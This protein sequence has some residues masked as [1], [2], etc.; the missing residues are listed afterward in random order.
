MAHQLY[1]VD[2]FLG[3]L[4][5]GSLGCLLQRESEALKCLVLI[6]HADLRL[7]LQG[8]TSKRKHFFNPQKENPQRVEEDGFNCLTFIQKIALI[9]PNRFFLCFPLSPLI[10]IH[11]RYTV[12]QL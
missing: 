8:A 5:Q 2:A 4:L 1:V 11:I 3:K 6:L 9:T 7:H 10:Q 12:K